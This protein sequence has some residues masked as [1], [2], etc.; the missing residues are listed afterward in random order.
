VTPVLRAGELS[1]P[2]RP[3]KPSR[4]AK[5]TQTEP[6]RLTQDVAVN[7]F[8]NCCFHLE[9]RG[10]LISGFQRTQ[11]GWHIQARRCDCDVCCEGRQERA[12]RTNPKTVRS[13][14]GKRFFAKLREEIGKP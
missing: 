1:K 11:H 12:R 13:E 7:E 4:T 5:L 14:D 8:R 6:E 9:S 3:P 10:Y 2:P